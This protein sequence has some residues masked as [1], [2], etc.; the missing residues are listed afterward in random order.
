MSLHAI[1][2]RLEGDNYQHRF[3]WYQASLLLVRG[4]QVERVILECDAASGMDDVAVF[5]APPGIVAG[6]S[7]LVEA[8]YYQL[9]YHVDQRD[10]YA[11]DRLVA[12]GPGSKRSL[13][14]RIADAY[15]AVKAKHKGYRLTLLSN[16]DWAKDDP[17]RA[18]IHDNDG[19]LRDALLAA[20]GRTELAKIRAQWFTHVGMSEAEFD[21]FTRRLRFVPNYL[22]RAGLAVALSDRLATA[23]LIPLDRTVSSSPYDDLA[24]KLVMN[25]TNDFTPD[26]FKELC[27]RERLL[28][29]APP[30]RKPR[31]GV[32]SFLRCAESME[33]ETD[34]FVCV[35]KDFDGRA[36]RTADSWTAAVRPTVTGFLAGN[37]ERLR[38]EPHEL[39]LDCH[40]TLAF[41][42]GYELDP[43]GGVTA[44]PVQK[45]PEGAV[46]WK[47]GA[48]APPA[49]AGWT[50]QNDDGDP[51]AEDV[52]LALSVTR[53]VAGDVAAFR[54]AS[55]LPARAILHARP[56]GG[57][58]QRSVQGA[59]HAVALADA[60]QNAIFD[61]R[62]SLPA[63]GRL[64]VFAA[65]PN[66]LLF[67]FGQRARRLGAITLYEFDF[68]GTRGG[69]Y[70]KSLELP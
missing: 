67:F 6:A 7:P 26:T 62:K 40:Q 13:L 64:H 15:K 31:L 57:I 52:V 38:R 27:V 23:G 32:R 70:T 22:S 34:A 30:P 47:P 58:G 43:K 21:D 10:A 18:Q 54:E 11:T 1:A 28:A 46:V 24:Q 61:L 5:Y 56:A 60:L 42:A 16:W 19:A 53:D 9:K 45:G 69:S 14:A 37:M 4:S 41:L 65:A 29:D 50:T 63:K 33:A 25:G 3:F 36:P 35:A 66:A 48:G 12:T 59:D 2:A 68:E 39:L 51:A 49:D 55:P 17:L 20:T 44:F 8:D